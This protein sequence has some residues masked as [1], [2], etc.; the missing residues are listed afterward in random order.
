VLSDDVQG[1]HD[2]EQ[3]DAEMGDERKVEGRSGAVEAVVLVV[4]GKDGSARCCTAEITRS[5]DAAPRLQAWSDSDDVRNGGRF[6]D[7][8]RTGFT[9]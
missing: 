1:A 7:A 5:P 8:L 6:V 3:D 2:R 9:S 4:M